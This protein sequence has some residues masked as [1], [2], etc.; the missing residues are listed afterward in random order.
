MWEKSFQKNSHIKGHDTD[1][2]CQF[3]FFSCLML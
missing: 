2:G 3:G 1:S